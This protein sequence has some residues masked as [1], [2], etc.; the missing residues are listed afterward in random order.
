M[1]MAKLALERLGRMP[2]PNAAGRCHEPL[3]R[4]SA[5]RCRSRACRSNGSRSDAASFD[6]VS[7]E[8]HDHDKAEALVYNR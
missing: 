7:S 6:R 8:R 4:L 1:A 2:P 3:H 5:A